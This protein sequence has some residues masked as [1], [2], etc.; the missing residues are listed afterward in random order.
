MI[1]DVHVIGRDNEI[2][3][4]RKDQTLQIYYA[5]CTVEEGFWV[6]VVSFIP[7]INPL[8][9]RSVVSGQLQDSCKGTDG[10]PS[11]KTTLIS[12]CYLISKKH[13]FQM[14]K[15]EVIWGTKPLKCVATSHHLSTLIK[16]Y[17]LKY[18]NSTTTHKGFLGL[19]KSYFKYSWKVYW[20]SKL[21]IM[22]N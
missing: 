11:D 21:L 12:E 18:N 13:S 16:C 2:P 19:N 9:R 15:E 22:I 3:S 4:P 6:V 10:I 8:S 7:T 17:G 20:N 5:L 14:S 1:N